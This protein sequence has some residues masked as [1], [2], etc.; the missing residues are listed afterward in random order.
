MFKKAL[1]SGLIFLILVSVIT[2][3]PV[4]SVKASAKTAAKH[5]VFSEKTLKKRLD[6]VRDYYYNKQKELTKNTAVFSHWILFGETIQ[7][8]YYLKGKDLMFAFGTM[9]KNEYRLY[10]YKNQLVRL[11]IKEDGKAA[12]TYDQ[13]YTVLEKTA[14]DDVVVLYVG[15]ENFFR[16]KMEPYLTKKTEDTIDDMIM[17]TG[18]SKSKVT[19]HSSTGYG[20]DGHIV[21]IGTDVYTADLASDVKIEDYTNTPDSYKVRTVGY[22][23]KLIKQNYGALCFV[24]VKNGKIV[25]IELPFLP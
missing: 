20:S 14:H 7:L 1:K 3:M 6:T 22:V 17:I 11:I 10:F 21:T 19:Y 12:V 9:G 5:T 2:A 13:L 16:I 24:K 25:Y 4:W 15:L 18:I 23:K 8:D